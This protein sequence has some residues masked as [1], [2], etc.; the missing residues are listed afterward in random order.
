MASRAETSVVYAAGAVQGIVLVTFPAAS[1]IFTDPDRYDLSNTQYGVLFLPQVATAITASLLG[2]RFARRFGTKRVYLAGLACGLVSMALLI[3]SQFFES[4]TS[5]AFP[6]LLVATAFLGAG[7]GLTVPALNILTA[8]F[9]PAAVESSV[10]VLNA[11]LGLGTALAP[12]F[13]A[14]FVGLGFWWGLPLMSAILLSLLV[15]VSLGLPLRSGARSSAGAAAAAGI[16]RRFW[17]FAGFAVLY[18]VSETVNGNWSQLDMTSELGASTTGAAIALTAFWAMVTIGRVVFAAVDRWLA[19]RTTYHILPFLLAGVF[20]VIAFLPDAATYAG[21]LVFGV[22]GLG[23]SALLPLTI[24]FGEQE[25]AEIAAAVAGGV[26]AF[27]QVGYG[28]AAFG[29]GPL[30]DHGVKLP[31]IYGLSAIIAVAMGIASFGVTRA[32]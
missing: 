8:A 21:V 11:L 7:F 15:V 14:I 29:V 30:L 6:L 19:V 31:T 13:V 24:G 26:I 10:L 27:Y 4:D 20:V 28:I 5:V 18:G 16:P 1:T 25:L 32:R 22:A 12:V 17:M 23:C 3:V 9:H 2:A